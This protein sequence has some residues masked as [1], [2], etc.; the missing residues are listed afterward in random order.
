MPVGVCMHTLCECEYTYIYAFVYVCAF[1]LICVYAHMCVCVCIHIYAFVYVCA[2]ILICVYAHMC[3]CVCMC[4]HVC[5]CSHAWVYG[6]ECVRVCLCV[7]ACVMYVCFQEL[8][9]GPYTY[10]AST[11]SLSYTFYSSLLF[12]YLPIFAIYCET[13]SCN[14][15]QAILEL[16][17][18]LK[19]A[20]NLESPCL[21][22]LNK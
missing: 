13:G 8:N 10:L 17:V 3:V 5:I 14:V 15:T 20:L 7:H 4:V 2:F 19:W 11:Q 22:L 21:S 12:T 16:A 18:S 1:I 6:Y 9:L